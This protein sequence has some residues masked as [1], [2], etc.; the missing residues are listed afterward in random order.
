MT[1]QAR[2]TNP[3]RV[4]LLA[5]AAVA[6]LLVTLP[7]AGSFAAWNTSTPLGGTVTTGSLGI[8]TDTIGGGSWSKNGQWFNPLSDRVNAGS[9]L[10]YTVSNVPVTAVGNNLTAA[11]EQGVT[12]AV[13]PD[14][15][16]DH[17]HLSL[18]SE[19]ATIHGS[20]SDASAQQTVSLKLTV[21]ADKDLPAGVETIDLT[22]L[23]VTLS[24]G[25]SW[26]D[27]ATL[28]AG[29]LTTSA[30]SAA[31]G[32]VDLS[33]DLQYDEDNVIGFYLQDPAPGTTI[34]WDV[35]DSSGKEVI[36]KADDGLNTFDYTGT[37]KSMP[38]IEITGSF[39]GFGSPE[40]TTDLIGSLVNISGWTD[41]IGST[42]AS[43]AFLNASHLS[44]VN[45]L[46][47]TLRDASYMFKDAGTQADNLSLPA[48]RAE[49]VTT[50]AHMFD[51]ATTF[52][53]AVD[54]WDTT[55][56]TDM[57]FMFAGA[58]SFTGPVTFTATGK[59]TTMEGM[60]QNASSYIGA[61]WDGGAI[62]QHWDVS[63]VTNMAHMF[64][65]ASA[66]DRRLDQWDVSS[67]RDMS[68][69][70]QGAT[71]FNQDLSAW[72][73][74]AVTTMSGMFNGSTAFNQ[75]VSRWNTGKVQSFSNMF[76]GATS[77]N[78]DIGAWAVSNATNMSSMFQGASQ[79]NQDISRWNTSKV[80]TMQAMFKDAVAFSRN[81]SGWD[82]AKVGN[83]KE[84]S[85]GSALTPEQLPVWAGTMAAA[86][87]ASA[88]TTA[89]D[90]TAVDDAPTSAEQSPAPEEPAGDD[91][92]AGDEATPSPE[93]TDTETSSPE[94]TDPEPADLDQAVD[95][96]EEAWKKAQ[97]S[98][99]DE[100][101]QALQ[102]A[103]DVVDA[104]LGEG[105]ADEVVQRLEDEE[106][107]SATAPSARP[108]ATPE[109]DQAD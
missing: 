91:G 106:A 72:N 83:H 4:I 82:V 88:A 99:T 86:P 29:A 58:T 31:G 16:K 22:R 67:V 56:V 21:S 63:E 98:D 8:G 62:I 90:E 100:A 28:N 46:P 70:F 10:V 51:G 92:S 105:S 57:S 55:N 87:A 76:K 45:A 26:T 47:N 7:G 66:F 102:D 109:G 49:N 94:P 17:I 39:D 3:L 34:K 104:L 42:S 89:D 50:M 41:A 13:M 27:T 43:Y 64:D 59:V 36:T 24:N 48:W 71:S 95:A 101:R 65:G 15:I 103:A 81:L 40:Q 37:G 1:R 6:A 52:V 69:M 20:A 75:S 80:T 5:M 2:S 85:D 93:P 74:A 77:F 23:T 61:P 79:F 25:H 11:F 108:M 53:K 14:T 68:S 96:L 73:T 78:Q 54:N 84:F 9:T 107:Q 97:E 60:F 30:T 38:W 35:W 33:F 32:K 44:R 18:T 19:P 12:G